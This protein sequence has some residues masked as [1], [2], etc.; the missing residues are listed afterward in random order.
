M[1]CGLLS[2]STLTYKSSLS[3]QNKVCTFWPESKLYHCPFSLSLCFE[4]RSQNKRERVLSLSSSPHQL[5]KNRAKED[6]KS[7]LDV[8]PSSIFNFAFISYCVSICTLWPKGLKLFYS[9]H[10]IFSFFSYILISL[11]ESR[12]VPT[13][14]SS[15]K[16]AMCVTKSITDVEFSIGQNVRTSESRQLCLMHQRDDVDIDLSPTQSML[17]CSRRRQWNTPDVIYIHRG[18][19]NPNDTSGN[20][21]SDVIYVRR[22]KH[23][24]LMY[25]ICWDKFIFY[26]FVIF[27]N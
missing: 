11:Q 24:I 9:I 15:V 23:M 1:V 4:V 12:G 5:A 27:T 26:L 16:I 17:M 19:D 14:Q 25:K 10:C 6:E 22:G 3:L 20:V 7:Y 18:N 13:Q 8:V 21:F 2:T